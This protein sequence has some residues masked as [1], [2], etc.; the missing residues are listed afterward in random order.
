MPPFRSPARRQLF[1]MVVWIVVL[2][3]VAVGLYFLAGIRDA[4][5]GVRTAFTIAWTVATLA[6]VGLGL[7]RIRRERQRG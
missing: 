7:K 6:V 5:R 4:D 1:T 2:D 3:A